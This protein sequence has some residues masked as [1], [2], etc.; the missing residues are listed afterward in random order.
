[1][2]VSA[3]LQTVARMQHT[4]SRRRCCRF[5][6]MPFYR[7]SGVLWIIIYLFVCCIMVNETHRIKGP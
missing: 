5:Q 7:S 1:L 2:G 4:R 3:S 6:L